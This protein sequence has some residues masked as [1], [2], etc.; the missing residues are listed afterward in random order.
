M[1]DAFF[2]IQIREKNVKKSWIPTPDLMADT[3]ARQL[4]PW[5]I[6][7]KKFAGIHIENPQ[8]MTLSV[9][10]ERPNSNAP[11]PLGGKKFLRF[12]LTKTDSG[13]ILQITSWIQYGQYKRKINWAH[14]TPT[15]TPKNQ[16]K[17]GQALWLH[18]TIFCKGG[19]IEWAPIGNRT[20]ARLRTEAERGGGW[21][22]R[23][24]AVGFGLF[25]KLLEDDWVA[26]R[27]CHF[28]VGKRGVVEK[29]ICDQFLWWK[30]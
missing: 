20:I 7:F 12:A 4:L 13:C 26:C 5:K 21:W 25:V 30:K 17:S 22:R 27:R 11:P 8:G 16:R 2:Q 28:V 9:E 3:E 29:T 24:L 15:R 14:T 1:K 6:R 23:P 18:G 10:K 19:G